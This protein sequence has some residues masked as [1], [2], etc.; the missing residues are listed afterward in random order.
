MLPLLMV[1]IKNKID[2][3]DPNLYYFELN[4]PQ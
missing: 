2:E 3:E 1:Y 4:C